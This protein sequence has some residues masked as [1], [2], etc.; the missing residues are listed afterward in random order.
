MTVTSGTTQPTTDL[1]FNVTD[2]LS[3]LTTELDKMEYEKLLKAN[4]IDLEVENEETDLKNPVMSLEEGS[5]I[6]L[7]EGEVI[8]EE[9]MLEEAS[10]KMSEL[11]NKL[12]RVSADAVN[13]S[14]QSEIDIANAKKIAKKGLVKDILPFM[15]ATVLSFAYIPE[16]EEAKKFA[17]T[18]K[19]SLEKLSKDLSSHGIEFIIPA[20]GDQF[21]AGIMQALNSPTTDEQLITNVASVGCRIDGQ[22][23]SPASVLL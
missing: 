13:A 15:T 16:N 2:N 18:L 8:V 10:L 23:I 4:D 20:I 5:G 3:E 19:S 11:E 1:D 6:L 14:K 22:L 7:K 9:K 17:N 21:D 12:I